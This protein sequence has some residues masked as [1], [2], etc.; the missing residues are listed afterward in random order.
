M[1]KG[2]MEGK[3]IYYYLDGRVY[4]GEWRRGVKQGYGVEEGDNTY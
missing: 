4:K 3:G 1:A 2:L